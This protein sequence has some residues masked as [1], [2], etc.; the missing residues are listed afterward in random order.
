MGV[1]GVPRE[2]QCSYHAMKF[3]DYKSS[4]TVIEIA[5][6]VG[7]AQEANAVLEQ[8]GSSIISG[9]RKI[10]KNLDK[11]RLAVQEGEIEEI[12]LRSHVADLRRDLYTKLK[13]LLNVTKAI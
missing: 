11:A 8:S 5:T 13:A 9:I 7:A 3:K 10:R 2:K 6:C 12:A 1:H 4:V